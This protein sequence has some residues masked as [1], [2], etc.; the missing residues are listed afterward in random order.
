MIRTIKAYSLEMNRNKWSELEAVAQAYAS[1]KADHLQTF[2]DA[3]IFGNLATHEQ[4]RDALL[5]SDYTSAYA[6]QARMWKLALKDAYETVVKQWAALAVDLRGRIH[7]RTGW[8]PA[9]KHYALWLLK[10][11]Q[12]LA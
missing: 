11:E 6:L 3:A 1:E 10:D 2:N 4:F 8:S 12:R 7:P 5:D 9:Q